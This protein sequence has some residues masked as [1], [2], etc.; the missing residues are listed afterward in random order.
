MD[1][2]SYRS[3]DLPR[4][5]VKKSI[6][7]AVFGNTFVKIGFVLISVFLLYNVTHSIDITMQKVGI[8]ENARSEVETL[9][10]TNLK[11]ATQLQNMQS[12]EYIEVE[13]RDRLNFSGNKDLVFVIPDGLLSTAKERLDS[14]LNAKPIESEKT[15]LQQWG[16]LLIQGV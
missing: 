14:I 9:R 1:K 15:I 2:V 13:A 5:I 8:L 16:E 7:P 3:N 6:A 4:R 12:P 10:V 11:L